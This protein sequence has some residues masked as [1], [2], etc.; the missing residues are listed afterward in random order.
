MNKTI[1]TIVVIALALIGGYFLIKGNTQVPQSNVNQQSNILPETNANIEP[2]T[3]QSVENYEV[4]Y[5]DSGY[6]P[7]ELTVKVGDTV[8]WKN[9]NS[10]GMWTAS[11]MHPTHIIYGGTSLDEHCPDMQNTSFDECK[12]AQPGES[13]SFT[14]DKK[15]T[16]RYH[17][18]VQASDFGSVIVE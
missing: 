8:T 7:K 16:W 2:S 15:G 4:K 12:S 17:N 14:F 9:E 13:W 1:I 18:H 11:A 6:A 10:N 3:T 5:T